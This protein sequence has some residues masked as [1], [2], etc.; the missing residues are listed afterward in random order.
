MDMRSNPA[1]LLGS[2]KLGA[3][4]EGPLTIGFLALALGIPA[5]SQEPPR[6]AESVADAARNAREHKAN[7]TNHPKTFTNDD[8][9]GQSPQPSAQATPPKSSSTNEAEAQ[10]PSNAGCDNP[11]AEKLKAN[12]QAAQEQQ[13]QI[14]RELSYNPTVISGGDLDSSNFKPGSSG[15]NVGGPPLL[16]STP[17]SPARVTEISL[18]DK[19][20]SLTRA[21]RIA[22]DSPEDAKIQMQLD[23]AEQQLSLLQREFDLDQAAY[24]SNPDYAGD[25]AGKSRLDAE[26]QQIQ[27]LQ[28]EI[29]RLKDELAASN[30]NQ[31]PK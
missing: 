16:E 9:V 11:D 6:P 8:L 10:Q 28:S 30:A 25:T 13:D 20:A 7:S 31:P 2:A 22:C 14:R 3:F 4:W 26:Q 17:L 21:L 29:E 19:I 24:Y 12:L 1:Q 18:E 23:Q 15:L 5:R 27:E